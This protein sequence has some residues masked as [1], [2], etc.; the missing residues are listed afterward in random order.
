MFWGEVILN[1]YQSPEVPDAAGLLVRV[2]AIRREVAVA[3]VAVFQ[4]LPAS[5]KQTCQLAAFLWN[6]GH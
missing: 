5:L 1:C 2:R 4:G 3:R 6:K